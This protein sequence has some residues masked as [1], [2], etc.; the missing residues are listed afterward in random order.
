MTVFCHV[1]EHSFKKIIPILQSPRNSGVS[2]VPDWLPSAV[3]VIAGLCSTASF[4]PQVLKVWRDPDTKAI[5]LRMYLVTV[6]AFALWIGYGIMIGS[7]PIMIFNT[8]SLVLSGLILFV[9]IRNMRQGR[10]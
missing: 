10:D 6:T 9:K 3:G 1:A 4:T 5:S 8:L 7:W 2:H